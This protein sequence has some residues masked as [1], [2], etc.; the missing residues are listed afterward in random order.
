MLKEFKEFIINNKLFDKEDKILLAISGGIDSMV[1]LDLFQKSNF[2]FSIA[3]CNFQLRENDSNLDEKFV[4]NYAAKNGI[5]CYI[6]KFETLEYKNQNNISTQMAARD[7]RY[8][9]FEEIANKNNYKYIA[10]AHHLDDQ[11]ETFFI[12]LIRGTGIAG[13]HGILAKNSNNIIRPLLFADREMIEAYHRNNNL[14]FRKDKSNDLDKYLRNYIRHNILPEFKKLNR[15]FAFTLN[16]NLS[17]LRE[18]EEVYKL[19]IYHK[20]AELLDLQEEKIIIN[21]Q[22][23]KKLEP[24]K[25]YLFEFLTLYNFN[26]SCIND[27]INTLEKEE[28]GKQY[29]SST[30]RIIK[31][32]KSLILVPFENNVYNPP[33]KFLI[34]ADFTSIRK[35]LKLNFEVSSVLKIIKND[36]IAQLDFD[37]LEFPLEIRKWQVGDYFYPLGMKNKKKLSD[38][39]I[40][41]KISVY[42]KE[43]AWLLTSEK[44]IVWVIGYRL[45]ERFKIDKKTKKVFKIELL[46]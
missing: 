43:S 32:R 2:I 13:M 42:D 25:P 6:K 5:K 29:F 40:D 9:W 14:D 23:L 26:E 28:S 15:N 35:P 10:T 16:N 38:Y 44:K 33:E 7:L 17:K 8:D 34:K 24:L 36:N 45:D 27:L 39:F 18:V 1:M 19:T 12:N 3:H 30:N 37:K 20:M 31:N 46:K 21:I 4:K 11:I 22:E 41:E